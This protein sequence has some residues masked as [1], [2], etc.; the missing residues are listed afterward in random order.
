MFRSCDQCAT[1]LLLRH[2][3][4]NRTNIPPVRTTE[5]ITCWGLQQIATF[6]SAAAAYCARN[7]R[8]RW[9]TRRSEKERKITST[10]QQRNAHARCKSIIRRITQT[11]IQLLE[12]H[13]A[14][15]VNSMRTGPDYGV[16]MNAC[17]RHFLWTL[18]QN[19]KE[20]L[21]SVRCRLPV[22]AYSARDKTSR[23]SL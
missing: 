6:V 3:F 1:L 21:S 17:N 7:N 4:V 2:P 11:T 8:W 23:K 9:Q 10:W 15:L 20:R 5:L 14:F 18:E 16:L 22:D 13:P 12:R 19:K